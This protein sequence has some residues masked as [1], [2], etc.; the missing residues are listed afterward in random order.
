MHSG[1][2]QWPLAFGATFFHPESTVAPLREWQQ[3]GHSFTGER[4]APF[5]DNPGK[6]K[7][8]REPVPSWILVMHRGPAAPTCS[9]A[10][11]S[12]LPSISQGPMERKE[13]FIARLVGCK[14]SGKTGSRLP[15]GTISLRSPGQDTSCLCASVS[16]ARNL[17]SLYHTWCFT[18][19]HGSA[20]TSSWFCN[21]SNDG[22]EKLCLSRTFHD[23]PS[24]RWH[25]PRLLAS[26][27]GEDGD[28]F[29]HKT[30]VELHRSWHS[31]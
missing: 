5:C 13:D 3:L 2:E 1:G 14:Y 17:F 25:L 15:S 6:G 28:T 19:R 10:F 4:R 21:P 7:R 8:Q 30:G 16:L 11:Y 23:M 20:K 29:G 12:L 18:Q 22:S 26:T 31:W 27:L 24:I 9:K